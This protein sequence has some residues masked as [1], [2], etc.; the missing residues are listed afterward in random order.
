ML[1]RIRFLLKVEQD[2]VAWAGDGSP[3]DL[4]KT[5]HFKGLQ[6]RGR[7]KET[8]PEAALD[9]AVLARRKI[10]EQDAKMSFEAPD[11]GLRVRLEKIFWVFTGESLHKNRF[12]QLRM[13]MKLTFG[14]LVSKLCIS[15]WHAFGSTS[16]SLRLQSRTEDPLNGSQACTLL[17]RGRWIIHL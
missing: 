13:A 4:S 14:T 15:C 11:A 3:Q 2:P 9:T 8:A 16:R 1:S 10:M 7:R 6:K 17:L 5:S 12:E